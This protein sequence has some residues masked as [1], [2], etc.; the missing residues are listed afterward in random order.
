MQIFNQFEVAVTRAAVFRFLRDVGRL[1][2]CLPGCRDLKQLEADRYTAAIEVAVAFLKLKFD[3]SVEV[4]E[5]EEP[6]RLKARVTGRPATLAG[7]LT[8]SAD[9]ALTEVGPDRT[10]VSYALD[11]SL[12]GKLGSIGQSAFRAKAEEM[13]ALFARNLKQALEGASAEVSA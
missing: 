1:A 4:V 11:L 7:Q 8:M 5:A 6:A 12:T 10:S 3:V 9:L 2:P 13:G